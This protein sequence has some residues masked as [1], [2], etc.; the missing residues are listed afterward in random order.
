MNMK[1]Q[2]RCRWS[3]HGRSLRNV[4]T[5]LILLV[6][7]SAD[8]RTMPTALFSPDNLPH[9]Q[10]LGLTRVFLGVLPPERSNFTTAKERGR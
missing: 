10:C 8:N 7:P 4:V 6:A 5:G 9:V 3:M 2:R 1:H